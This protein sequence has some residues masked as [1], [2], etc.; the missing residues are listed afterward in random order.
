LPENTQASSFR[1]FHDP[2]IQKVADDHT[3]SP[4]N[5]ANPFGKLQPRGKKLQLGRWAEYPLEFVGQ[6][7]EVFGHIS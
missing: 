6:D 2:V 1:P 7:F 3:A 4:L 5:P